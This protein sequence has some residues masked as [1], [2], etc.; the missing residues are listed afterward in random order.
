MKGKNKKSL[1]NVTF[2]PQMINL[3]LRLSE[4]TL[5]ITVKVPPTDSVY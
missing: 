5:N 4:L 1:F 3:G 2:I